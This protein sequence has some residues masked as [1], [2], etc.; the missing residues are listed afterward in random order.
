MKR[1]LRPVL[2]GDW[3]LIGPSPDLEK[4]LGP[5]MPPEAGKEHNAVVDHHVFHDHVGLWHLWACV[6]ATACGRVL[7]HWTSPRLA[8]S[9]W[10]AS[11]EVIRCDR[12]A[13]EAL[14]SYGGQEWMQS[15]Y[16]VNEGGTFYMFY[17][18]HTTGVGPDGL[19]AH[20]VEDRNECQICLMTSPDGRNWTRHRD[21]RGYSR[22][23]TG[24]GEARDPC[25]INIGGLWYCYYAGYEPGERFR[26]GFYARTSTDLIHWSPAKCIHR[27]LKLAGGRWDHECPHVV[28]RDG[29]FY[30]FR[31][32]NYYNLKSHVFRSEDPLDFGV[33]SGEKYLCPFPAAAVEVI[34][35]GEGKEYVTS[36]HRPP[37]GAE[38]CRLTWELDE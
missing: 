37:V 23:F 25:V 18:G 29:Y 20:G 30:L 9:P 26:P 19:P 3:W 7:Y 4:Q 28:Q 16:V 5:S 36:V 31:T 13:G 8:A 15:P 35:D 34:V 38:M 10:T 12:V 2:D 27:D 21:E 22:V 6:R 14:D 17:G 32:E 1:K 11:G 24:P 33:D